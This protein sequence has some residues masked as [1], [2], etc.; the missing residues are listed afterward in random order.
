[1]P[2]VTAVW[3]RLATPVSQR[4]LKVALAANLTAIDHADF[5]MCLHRGLSALGLHSNLGK[6][7]SRDVIPPRNERHEVTAGRSVRNATF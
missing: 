1:M 3:R 7:V 6:D 4:D 2:A 5:Y